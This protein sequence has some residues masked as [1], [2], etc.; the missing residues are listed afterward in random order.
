MHLV[1]RIFRGPHSGTLDRRPVNSHFLH[2]L[3]I[4]CTRRLTI[5]VT[6]SGSLLCGFACGDT[7]EQAKNRTDSGAGA[8]PATGGSAATGNTDAG[9]DDAPGDDGLLGD[10]PDRP[11]A[12]VWQPHFE[13]SNPG[14]RNST[15]PLCTE[16]FGVMGAAPEIWSE[17]DTVFALVSAQCNPFVKPCGGEG[18][19]LYENAGG[20]WAP[21]YEVASSGSNTHLTGVPFGELVVYN[22]SCGITFIDHQGVSKCSWRDQQYNGVQ[23]AF[24]LP[25]GSG[26][27]LSR[28]T[29]LKYDGATWGSFATFPTLASTLS[30]AIWA[31]TQNIVVTG[32]Q[33]F[34]VRGDQSGTFSP[35]PS[36]PAGD[37]TSVWAFSADDIWLANRVGHLLHYTGSIW[38]TIDTG[39]G[40]EI[41][42]LWGSDDGVLYFISAQDFGRYNNE[43]LEILIQAPE[44]DNGVSFSSL[45][46]N[47]SNEVFVGVRDLDFSDYECSGVFAVFFDGTAFHLF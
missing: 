13:L 21:L 38:Q 47:W 4:Y 31:N 24:M 19:T 2:A 17:L 32:F 28:D 22:D 6:L 30:G 25:N 26:Y 5:A 43:G 10:A 41:L 40:R 3:L 20:G 29:L 44:V 11:P 14:W 39:I 16:R 9:A 36:L 27:A 46:G 15:E 35:L 7:T 12:P 18:T 45:W 8:A 33:Q 37:Y 34:V 1:G 23:H 42:H